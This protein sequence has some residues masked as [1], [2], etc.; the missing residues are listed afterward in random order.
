MRELEREGLLLK[1]A[2]G[3]EWVAARKRPQRHVDLRGCGASCTIVDAE[4]RPIGSVDGHQA[5]KETHPGA[6]YLHRGKTYVVKSLDMAERVVRCEVPQQR[7]NWHTRVRSHKETAIIEVKASGSAF[8]APVAFGRL[9]VTETITGYEQRSVADNRLLC[10]VPLD[11]PPL[12]FETEGL[13]FCV[14]D[15]PRRATEDSLMHF[16]GS[17]HALE[18]A[19]IGLMPLMVMADRNDFG[20]IS[21]PMHAQLGMPAVFVYD[22]LPLSLIHI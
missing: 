8:G 15:G 11:L 5:Y 1:S 3:R 18:H 13:W 6:V 14:P 2:D 16:M 4:G 7:V 22:G 19:S 10:V 21:T 17:I 9:R 12:V 20:G